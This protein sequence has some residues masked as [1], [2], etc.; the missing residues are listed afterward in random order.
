MFVA[1]LEASRVPFSQAIRECRAAGA[2]S[3]AIFIGPEGDFSTEEYRRIADAGARAVGLG[4]QI[5]RTETAAIFGLS[6]LAYELL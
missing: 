1:S 6:V 4:S 2:R 3:A 5:L